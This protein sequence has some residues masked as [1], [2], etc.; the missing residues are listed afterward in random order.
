MP[1]FRAMRPRRAGLDARGD[2]DEGRNGGEGIDEEEDGAE[3]EQR[4]LDVGRVEGLFGGGGRGDG[5]HMSRKM[6]KQM[7]LKVHFLSVTQTFDAAGAAGLTGG[8]AVGNFAARG[9]EIPVRN[10]L[11]GGHFSATADWS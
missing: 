3:R 1:A 11:S 5:R 9:E 10:W 7:G 8:S 2:G 6:L 4:E